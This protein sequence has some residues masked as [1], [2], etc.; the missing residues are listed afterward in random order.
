MHPIRCCLDCAI[1]K[2]W[3]YRPLSKSIIALLTIQI[4]QKP[5]QDKKVKLTPQSKIV[6][7]QVAK[8]VKSAEALKG[9]S[10]RYAK[11]GSGFLEIAF[12]RKN[13][14][15]LCVNSVSGSQGIFLLS[16]LSSPLN[17]KNERP[18]RQAFI[19]HHAM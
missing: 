11:F 1:R 3:Q 13:R 15:P 9:K 12:H 5:S 7:D 2:I 6:A 8:L 10:F 4:V 14:P 18:T 19:S 16:T 17:S